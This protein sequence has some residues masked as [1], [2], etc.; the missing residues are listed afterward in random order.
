MHSIFLRK[1]EKR[2]LLGV[3]PEKTAFICEKFINRMHY[4]KEEIDICLRNCP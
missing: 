3:Y 1:H 4:I 2:V